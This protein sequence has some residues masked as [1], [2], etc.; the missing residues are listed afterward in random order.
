MA[1]AGKKVTKFMIKI[2]IKITI[3]NQHKN[4]PTP[5]T[6]PNQANLSTR[7]ICPGVLDIPLSSS[8]FLP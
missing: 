2:T 6:G 8:I 1:N 4:P 7:P 3:A 5:R